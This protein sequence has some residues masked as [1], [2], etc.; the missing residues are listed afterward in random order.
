MIERNLRQ[1]NYNPDVLSC[2][3]NLSSD[4]VFTP[5]EIANKMLDIL[6]QN[7]FKNKTVTFLDPACKSGVFLREAAKRLLVG[8][9]DEIPILQNRIDHI[10][11]KQ[12]F[13]L[14]I[15]EL[16]S[17]LARRSLYCSKYPNSAYSIT[18]FDNAEG[19]I[20]YKQINHTW[21]NDKCALCGASKSVFN[22]ENTLESHAYE[23]IHATKPEEI[24]KMKFDVIIGN[25]P[26][27]LNDGGNGRSATPIYHKFVE[28]SL[29]FNPRFI[30]M[31]I[32]SRWFAGGKGLDKFR[33]M[34][35][36]DTHF[37]K[38][39]DF[40][41]A[42]ECFP[43]VD[44]AGGICYF[45]WDREYAGD[46]KVSNISKENIFTSLR[47]LNEFDIFVRNG[48]SVPIIQKVLRFKE[49]L[50]KDQVSS[51]KPFGL[52]TNTRPNNSGDLILRW[53]GGDGFFHRSKISVGLDMIDKYKVICAKTAYDHAGNPGKDGKRKIFSNI[54]IL[55]PGS[56]CTETYLVAGSFD[57]EVEAQNLR[58]YLM[59]YFVRFLIIPFLISQDITKDRFAFVPVQDFSQDWTDKK[60]YAKYNIS[61]DEIAYIESLLRP[62]EI[63]DDIC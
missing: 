58:Q 13:G 45:L 38:I 8:L 1:N 56:I 50:M 27:Q 22:H 44:I 59:T 39:F 60:L 11:Q 20:R 19:N 47:S 53:Q 30:T 25:P 21:K 33:E 3:A 18:N 46:C 52:P 41:N 14:S 37:K 48:R 43:G 31:I 10:F 15:T 57:S 63:D 36:N 32:P 23:F 28:Q 40:E 7:I 51:R 6:P 26:Y 17:L 61:I 4:E 54:N 62:M 9:E 16:T 49:P 55:P 35:L 2:L 12:L 29:K 5:P 42:S 34:M 24:F